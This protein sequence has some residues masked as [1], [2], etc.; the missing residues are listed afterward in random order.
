[1]ILLPS[2]ADVREEV[3]KALDEDGRPLVDAVIFVPTRSDEAAATAIEAWL[4]LR[5]DAPSTAFGDLRDSSGRS[6]RYA[7]V[8]LS[9]WPPRRN[10]AAAA[11]VGGSRRAE[12]AVAAS[13]EA[14]TTEVD[15]A[16]GGLEPLPPRSSASLPSGPW[17]GWSPIS[18]RRTRRPPSCRGSVGASSQ[19]VVEE[20]R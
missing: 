12:V 5:H 11:G 7:T 8:N 20:R 6:C 10:R 16:G 15:E 1:M 18:N 3:D 13:I 14:L 9:P 17:T 2:T 4:R 19:A